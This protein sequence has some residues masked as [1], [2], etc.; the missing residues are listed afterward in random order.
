MEVLE[1]AKARYAA[2]KYDSNKRIPQETVDALKEVLR[3]SPSSINIQPWK[4]TFVQ[5]K[6][7]KSQLAAASL[8]NES[9]INEADL[10]VVFSVA[11]DLEE[12]QHVVDT[13]LPEGLRNWYNSIKNEIPEEHLRVWLSKQVYITMGVALSAAVSLGLDST[14]MEGIETDK[15]VEIL[16]MTTYK[17]LFA[18]AFGY[19]AED[20]YNRPEVTPKSRR[21]LEDVVETI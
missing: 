8:H 10:L 7:V 17:P 2:K 1:L 14:P 19:A 18:I 11:D 6:E 13:N 12:F 15:Y 20:D 5:N 9:K 4:F 16:G 21:E 3:L